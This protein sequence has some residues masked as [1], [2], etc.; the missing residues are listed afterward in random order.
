M[1]WQ[2]QEEMRTAQRHSK[3]WKCCPRI[4]SGRP[5][6]AAEISLASRKCAH[7]LPRS[8]NPTRVLQH[9]IPTV[10][11]EHPIAVY[12]FSASRA[13]R[14]RAANQ[15]RDVVGNLTGGKQGAKLR[16]D[17]HTGSGGSPHQHS[18]SVLAP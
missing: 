12:S 14:A 7:H 11:D 17:H 8:P 6:N 3:W 2:E 10:D 9:F 18:R 16:L 4:S 13:Y 5:P 15:I 1:R